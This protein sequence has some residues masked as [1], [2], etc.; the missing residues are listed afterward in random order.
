MK[1]ILFIFLIVFGFILTSCTTTKTY[2][3]TKTYVNKVSL[4]KEYY[5]E[6]GFYLN[7]TASNTDK[8]LLYVGTFSSVPIFYNDFFIKD[9]YKFKSN[10]GDYVNFTL[11]YKIDKFETFESG[12]EE[13][14]INYEIVHSEVC[15]CETNNYEL[16]EKLCKNRNILDFYNVNK[17][18]KI[19][20]SDTGGTLA[21]I[22]FG[23]LAAIMTW[24]MIK[25]L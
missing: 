19:I 2:M 18:D 24:Y 16:Y 14:N 22:G 12:G 21:I 3:S 6:N 9:T 13:K 15:D 5:N 7:G 11:G 4:L 25:N 23:S 17:V 8:T 1:K 20:V 10:N